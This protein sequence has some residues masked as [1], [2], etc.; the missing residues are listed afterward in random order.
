[1]KLY[2]CVSALQE[3]DITHEVILRRQRPTT[4]PQ[5]G[6]QITQISIDAFT[7]DLLAP[8]NSYFPN[9]STSKCNYIISQIRGKL[10]YTNEQLMTFMCIEFGYFANITS[11]QR[12]SL[13]AMIKLLYR[14]LHVEERR[15]IFN[16]S[17]GEHSNCVKTETPKILSYRA[18]IAHYTKQAKISRDAVRDCGRLAQYL[19]FE[20]MKKEGV[21]KKGWTD[22]LRGSD[23]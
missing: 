23:V 8:L 22:L 20:E 3:K 7:K 11:D 19:N 2:S 6:N 12:R 17:F 16:E 4:R 18:V 10:F 1:M 15:K 21:F 5:R 13:K 14:Y 9:V